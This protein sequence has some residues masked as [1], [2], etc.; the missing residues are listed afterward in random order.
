M[1]VLFH[2]LPLTSS[3]CVSR[4]SQC[5]ASN[6]C[7]VCRDSQCAELVKFVRSLPTYKCHR[8]KCGGLFLE[9]PTIEKIE[10]LVSNKSPDGTDGTHTIIIKPALIYK[11]IHKFSCMQ[12]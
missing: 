12:H 1:S 8:A 4:V 5:A 10:Q 3:H 9:A 6:Q 7:C 2:G 11:V